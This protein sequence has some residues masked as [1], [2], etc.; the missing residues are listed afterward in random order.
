MCARVAIVV[1]MLA[2]ALAVAGGPNGD[3]NFDLA[4]AQSDSG[5][6]SLKQSA[7]PPCPWD[8]DGSN[9]H[10]VGVAD[11]LALLAQWGQPS[12]CDFD[13]NGVGVTDFLLVL[14]HWG[15]CPLPEP[16]LGGY[17]NS[18]CLP[19][20]AGPYQACEEDDAFE[21]VVEGDRLSV[22]HQNATYN[23]C[24]EDIEVSLVVEGWLLTLTEEEILVQPCYCICCYEV[25][26]TVED[27]APGEY[28]VEYWWFD[29]EADQQRC[30]V[31]VVVIP[32][33]PT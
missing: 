13:G 17:A 10:L 26:S 16:H 6:G 23:C 15:P 28:V 9:D 22:T 14:A 30:H 5:P 18:G 20:G 4:V 2:G 8:C 29:Y 27:L 32:G 25:T 19:E 3:S 31:E 7:P 24:P 33:E 1:L 21:F 12:P 11:F